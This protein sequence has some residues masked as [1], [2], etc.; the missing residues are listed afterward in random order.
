MAHLLEHMLFKG[1][2]RH[3]NTTKE[4]QDHGSRP[5]GTTWFDRTNYF[6]TF[7]ASDANLEW[8][9]DLEADRRVNPL[10]AKK[11]LDSEMTVVRNGIER[12]EQSPIDVTAERVM[13]T[14]FARP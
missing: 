4:L 8:A 14:P 9:V 5:D 10:V 13:S 12:G 1:S 3:P 6:E 7:Q 11:D 2:A